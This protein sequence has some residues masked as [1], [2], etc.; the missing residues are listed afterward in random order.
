MK[1][2]KIA[3]YL[4]ALCG[5]CVL[6]GAASASAALPE[7]LPATGTFLSTS[8][9]GTLETASGN[10]VECSSDTDKGSITGAK[11]VGG[12]LVTFSGCKAI[13]GILKPSCNTAGSSKGV[14]ETK[15]LSGTLGYINKTSKS[16]GL[17][18]KPTTGP[19]FVEFECTGLAI[20]KVRGALIGRVNPINTKSTS[21]ELIY[22][23]SAGVQEFKLLEGS[24][25]EEILESSLNGGSFETSGLTTTDKITF[26]QP[27]EVMA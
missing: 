2:M 3:L 13:I 5:L 9:S 24:A 6:G 18:L 11:A 16:V 7:F 25:A 1:R 10:K 26:H 21:G 14:I 22:K 12:V 4:T 27:T 15:E 20:N 23:Q 17:S 19:L 8:S